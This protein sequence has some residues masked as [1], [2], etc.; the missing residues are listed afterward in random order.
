MMLVRGHYTP[1][2]MKMK[3]LYTLLLGVGIALNQL[4]AVATEPQWKTLFAYNEV[5]TIAVS[6]Q[7]VYAVS[8]GSLFS[9]DK[10][11]ELITL[12]NSSSGLSGTDI[13]ALYYDEES[14]VLIIGYTDGKIDVLHGGRMEYISGLYTKDIVSTK[15]INN[16]SVHDGRAY[17]AMDFGIVTFHLTKHELVD[18]YYI[19]ANA[20]EV[21]VQDVV[22]QDDSIYAF[23]ASTIY[24]ASLQD[25]IVDYRYWTTESLG[26]IERDTNKGKRYTDASGDVWVA[27]GSE[28]VVRTMVTGNRLTYK[29]QGPLLNTPYDMTCSQGYLYVV[30]G[31]RWAT[32]NSTQGCVMVYDGTQWMNITQAS[33][34]SKTG[35]RAL[36]FMHAEPD[37]NDPLHFFVTSYGTGVYEFQGTEVV[38]HYTVDNSTLHSAAESAPQSYTRTT[39][40]QF[41]KAGGFWLLNAGVDVGQLQHIAADGTWTGITL[42][43][44]NRGKSCSTTADVILDNRNQNYKW[45]LLPRATGGVVLVDDKGTLDAADDHVVYRGALLEANGTETDLTALQLYKMRQDAEGNIWV[46]SNSGIFIIPE[47]E[48]F[49]T[50]AL[51]ERIDITEDNGET[52]FLTSSVYGIEFDNDGR[53]W[54]GTTTLGLYVLSAD[55]KS[56]VAHFTTDNSLMPSNYVMSLAWD[57]VG[58]TMYIGT[59]KGIV[60]CSDLS[61]A[62]DNNT[63]SDSEEEVDYGTMQQWRLHYSY[64]DMQKVVL[65]PTEVY[66]LANETLF[67]LNKQDE[68]LTDYNKST[69]L[70]GAVVADIAYD[71]TTGQ[72]VVGYTDGRIDLIAADGTV[73]AMPDL[74]QKASSMQVSINSVLAGSDRVY[75]AMPFGIVSVNPRKAEVMDTY[76]IGDSAQDVNVLRVAELG[77]TLYAVSATTLYYA[78]KNDNLLDYAYWKQAALP[79]AKA[80]VENLLVAH[81][82]PY[83][84]QG[85]Q[86]Y[87]RKDNAW[88]AVAGADSLRWVSGDKTH[89]FVY[90][91]GPGVLSI[92]EN[93]SLSVVGGYWVNDV[94]Y[95][96]STNVHWMAAPERGITRLTA[97]GREFFIPNGPVSNNGYRLRYAAGHIY[98]AGGAR[99]ATQSSRDGSF[100]IYDGSQWTN[101]SS[102]TIR[103]QAGM[104]L[105]PLDIVSI[106]ADPNDAGHFFACCYGM[107]VIEFRNYKGYKQYT[108]ENST[109]RSAAA[110][111]PTYYTRTEGAMVDDEGNL[112]V[113][114]TGDNS[115]PVNI[116]TPAGQWYGLDMYAGREAVHFATPWEITVDNRNT[117]YK[118]MIDQ[119]AAPGV[120]LLDDGGTPLSASDDRVVKRNTFIDGDNIQLTP[121]VLYC[122]AQDLDGDIWLGTPTGIIVIPSSVDFFA[123]NDCKRIKIPRN[124]G[125]NLA[126]YLLGTEQVNAIV[127]DGANRKWIGTQTSGIYLMSAD[128]LT[129]L[130]HFTTDNSVLPSNTI[131]SIA[132]HAQTGEVFAGTA[133]GI[134]SYKSDAADPHDDLSEAYA[135]PNPVRP[136]YQGMITIMGLME[137]T[138]VNIIDAGGNLVCK[139]ISNGGIAVWDGRNFRGERVGSGVYT[140]LCNAEGK[141]HTAVKILFMH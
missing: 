107:G 73:K 127:V 31:G 108:V 13:C 51:C 101:F 141:N 58:R 99:W 36:D 115:H 39:S 71:A 113:L 38:K 64:T 75:L 91:W 74:Y 93:D 87:E 124:D 104:S 89:L 129:T 72:V 100:S 19:G 97:Q 80:S 90:R 23:T 76:Y 106:G 17:L 130:A 77:D 109:L 7:Q 70:N 47:K 32:Q 60:S 14:D 79:S 54:I 122:L 56:I 118:W 126:D 48:D 40:G 4:F 110:D 114:N 103:T 94:V 98:V 131:L 6:P 61:T 83:L 45:I 105:R 20:A 128:G 119:R 111:N 42:N 57:K 25:N 139:T 28:G 123:S 120:V 67:A 11:T 69:G 2:P 26:R 116:M 29:P 81:G 35:K 135:Y 92:D 41:D 125:T 140:A 21:K 132:I 133:S 95:D 30:P 117:N 68:T 18:T 52:P 53:A 3:R 12:Y 88:H 10:Q 78:S 84:M 55:R 49:F 112:W 33:I 65:T 66:G 43:F 9:V 82:R 62:L 59:S 34:Q 16:I 15:T 134:A 121:A 27:G 136:N 102:S 44:T 63:S 50:S 8:A 1:N 5:T 138:T 22:F 86:L 85:T 96:P 137:N 24:K 46:G 37:P